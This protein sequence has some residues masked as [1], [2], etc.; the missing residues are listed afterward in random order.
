MKYYYGIIEF[1][2]FLINNDTYPLA[3]VRRVDQVKEFATPQEAW[4][5][6]VQA[7]SDSYISESARDADDRQY[8]MAFMGAK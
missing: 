4:D 5:F 8:E 1:G 6:Y 2:E 3:L 7:K